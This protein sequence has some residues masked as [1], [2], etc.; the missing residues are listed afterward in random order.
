MP[1]TITPC[2]ISMTVDAT[3]SNLIVIPETYSMVDLVDFAPRAVSG[4]PQFSTLG[5]YLDV[6][7]EG[8]G[9]GF[10]E[11]LFKE[12]LS[13]AYTGQS[14]DTRHGHIGLFTDHD[15][16]VSA[17][18]GFDPKKLLVHNT[19]VLMATN[20]GLSALKP[21]DGSRIEYTGVATN[22]DMIS[23]GKYLF[24][25]RSGRMKLIYVAQP[26]GVS[27]VT[28]TFTGAAFEASNQFATTGVVWVFDG[29]GVGT[30]ST[31]ASSGTDTVVVSAWA[32]DTPTTSSWVA[33]ICDAGNSGNP[34]SNFDKLT[35]FGGS[36]WAS[37]AS[38]NYVHFW[39]E[40]NGSD[41]EGGGETDAGVVIV[42]PPGYSIVNL[43]PF[44]NQLYIF[45]PDGVWVINEQDTDTVA[46]HPLDYS[47][48]VNTLN[49]K[50]VLAWQGF[51]IYAVRNNLYKFKSGIQV[52]TPPTWDEYPPYKQFGN[53]RGM[54]ARGKYL[55][56]LGQSNEA[57][58]DET[59]QATT[60][61]VSLLIHD[62]IGWHKPI[63]VPITTPG[64]FDAWLDA[65]HD[66]IYIYAATAAGVG[67]LFKVQVQT[68]SDI[69]Y[70]DYPTS[71]THNLYTSY[72]DFGMKRISKSFA[73]LTLHGDFPTNTSVVAAYRV[74]STTSWTTLGTFTT[75][76]QEINFASSVA[77]KRIQLRFSLATTSATS[78][79]AI[80]S[81]ILKVMLRPTV[82]WGI[83]CD[84]I[85]SNDVSDQNAMMG[86]LTAKEIKTN[87][88][89]A[90]DS[91][92][93][94]TFIDIYGSSY[95]AYLASVR[96]IVL[97]YEDSDAVQSVAK[98]T[99]T[100]V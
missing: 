17:V 74:D 76:L 80:K 61:F 66:V 75:D 33:V 60:G 21:S 44:T 34:P 50:T 19:V 53:F 25:S 49:F 15:T 79:P 30:V 32:G 1:N 59:T 37:E 57:N 84:V 40:T 86:Q 78:T 3:K 31:V 52:I 54:F 92:S 23:N 36:L 5:L 82:K 38:T 47:A 12:P 13:Y 39:S 4:T 46:Y 58:S 7:Q 64:S 9:H 68:Y 42:G 99:F 11:W 43:H 87:L 65:T 48:E 18:A 88:M 83:N 35:V 16:V 14:I 45:R 77:G 51:L 27:G 100:F 91:V 93:P 24:M 98:C 63:D 8:Y 62:G 89:A 55:Y 6:A 73:S 95:T 28:L 56:C 85:V 10:G 41:A 26:S 72:F 29:T 70:A 67:S 81:A 90:R 97:A 69:P 71:G 2:H 94:F 20:T 96:F 22:R